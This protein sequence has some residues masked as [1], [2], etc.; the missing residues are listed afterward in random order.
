MIARLFAFSRR[1]FIAD[2]AAPGKC[3]QRAERFWHVAKLILLRG[4]SLTEASPRLAGPEIAA[5]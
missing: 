3:R 5:F 1:C 2:L 4:V